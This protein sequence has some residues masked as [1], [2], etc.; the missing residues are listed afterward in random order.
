M[1]MAL[2]R[3]AQEALTN[4][5]R[6]ARAGKVLLALELGES[7]RKVRLTITDD[8]TGFDTLLREGPRTGWGLITMRERAEAVGGRFKL[9]S[10]SGQ[11]TRITVE[12][13]G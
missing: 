11:G 10:A 8:G 2:F 6:H 1:E 9:E 3:I 7:P 13:R 4:V 5:A 12:V